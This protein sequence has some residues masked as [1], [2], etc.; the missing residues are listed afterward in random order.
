MWQI[1]SYLK[2]VDYYKEFAEGY[3]TQ[4]ALRQGK[5]LFPVQKD[6]FLKY[7]GWVVAFSW[8]GDCLSHVTHYR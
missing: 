1:A 4:S 2:R 6:K 5:V 7:R 8:D 3:E